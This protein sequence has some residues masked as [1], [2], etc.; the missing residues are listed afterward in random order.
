[1]RRFLNWLE[2]RTYGQVL[3]IAVPVTLLCMALVRIYL[4]R[5]ASPFIAALLVVIFMEIKT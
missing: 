1:M 5:D 2:R 3:R 4:H